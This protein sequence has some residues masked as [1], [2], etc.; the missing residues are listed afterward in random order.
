MINGWTIDDAAAL[1]NPAMSAAQVRALVTIAGLEPIGKR[2]PGARG[3]RP[4]AVYDMGALMRAHAVVVAL[5]DSPA[6]L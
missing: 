6:S 3:G 1:L 2:R 5:L 4:A